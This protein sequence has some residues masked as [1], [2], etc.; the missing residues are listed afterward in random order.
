MDFKQVKLDNY[1][2]YFIK[3]DKFKTATISM[4]FVKE[5]KSINIRY[6]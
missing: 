2:I 3:T 6:K 4:N 1:N 5:I